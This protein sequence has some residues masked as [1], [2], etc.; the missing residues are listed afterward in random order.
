MKLKFSWKQAA[1]SGGGIL[2]KIK[3]DDVKVS[4]SERAGGA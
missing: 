4:A 1:A 3:I 2:N